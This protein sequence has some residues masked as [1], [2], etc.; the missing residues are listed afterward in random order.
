VCEESAAER[1]H[2][3]RF[4]ITTPRYVALFKIPRP[5]AGLPYI[6]AITQPRLRRLTRPHVAP[7]E[8]IPSAFNAA[9]MARGCVRLRIS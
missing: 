6:T 3:E 5:R 9:A 4:Q 7:G 8:G 2:F 1:I